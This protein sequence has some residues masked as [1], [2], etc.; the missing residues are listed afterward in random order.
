MVYLFL[1]TSPSLL[2]FPFALGFCLLSYLWRDGLKYIPILSRVGFSHPFLG[3]LHA[4]WDSTPTFGF[5]QKQTQ[6]NKGRA[7]DPSFFGPE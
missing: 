5:E 6:T 1:L 3:V 4:F 7:V 2:F